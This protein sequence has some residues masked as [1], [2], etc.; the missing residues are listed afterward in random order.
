MKDK[1]GQRNTTELFEE[2]KLWQISKINYRKLAEV[3]NTQLAEI[4]TIILQVSKMYKTQTAGDIFSIS[5]D[6]QNII[7]GDM[8]NQAYHIQS[9]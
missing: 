9:L 7:Q 8:K 1:I 5:K 2:L 4:E 3:A 6:L